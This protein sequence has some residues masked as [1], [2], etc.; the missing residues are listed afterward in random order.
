MYTSDELAE[1]VN[2]IHDI[3]GEEKYWTYISTEYQKC[4]CFKKHILVE[5]QKG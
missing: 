5:C 1:Y 2:I 3:S 4:E